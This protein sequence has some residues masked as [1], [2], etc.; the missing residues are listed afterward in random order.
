MEQAT[1]FPEKLEQLWAEHLKEEFE[2]KDVE[3]TLATMVEDAYVDHMPVHTGRRG[4]E[5]LRRFCREDFI[6]SGPED[7]QIT[8]HSVGFLAS[9]EFIPSGSQLRPGVRL[10]EESRR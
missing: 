2:T 4:E 9:P 7:L 6:S 3:A 10:L 5:L 8:A 1:L